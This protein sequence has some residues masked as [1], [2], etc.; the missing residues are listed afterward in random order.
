M[1][2]NPNQ[3]FFLNMLPVTLGIEAAHL[4]TKSLWLLVSAT[5][6]APANLPNY[7]LADQTQS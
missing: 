3:D 1:S 6:T 7:L 4:Q 5:P 2:F